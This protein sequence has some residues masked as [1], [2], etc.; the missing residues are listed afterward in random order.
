MSEIQAQPAIV[1]REMLERLFSGDSEALQGH[2]G[3]DDLSKLFPKVREAIPDFTA[4]LRQQVVE[5]ARV[6]SLWTFR[7]T[8]RGPLFGVPPTGRPIEFQNLS[9]A[10]V[11]DGKVV[12]YNSETG[13]LAFL[14]QVG[15]LPRPQ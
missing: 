9:I 4:E 12:E 10:R 13:W 11:T 2:P 5:G 7:G 15:A 14:M 8:H 6:A 3:M 1:V